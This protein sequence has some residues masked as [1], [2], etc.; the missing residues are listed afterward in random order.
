MLKICITGGSGFIGSHLLQVLEKKGVV[1]TILGRNVSTK[2][3]E[4]LSKDKVR[5]LKYDLASSANPS[6]DSLDTFDIL[7][8]LGGF[9]PRSIDR[10]DLEIGLRT[11]I[12]GTCNLLT[13]RRFRKVIYASTLEVY[14]TPKT[15][16]ITEDQTTDPT[17]YYGTSK[18]AGEK[19]VS[20][21][22]KQLGFDATILRFSSVY[23]SGEMYQRA[24]PNFI[25]RALQNQP[26]IIR[27]DGSDMRDYVHVAD[28]VDSIMLAMEGRSGVY[29]IASGVGYSIREIAEKILA[30]TGN[31]VNIS[32]ESSSKPPTKLVFDIS[33]AKEQLNYKPKVS[34]LEGLKEEIDWFRK[35]LQGEFKDEHLS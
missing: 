22:S 12:L 18:L 24:I 1:P 10:D 21:I 7:I 30:L 17:S 15:L 28:A 16:P 33:K 3:E 19:Y 29:N 8:H 34:I 5:F 20:A 14:G 11:N 6:L 26:L 23:G 4:L 25:R 32:F 35:M 2:I 27:G 13:H 9:V 31:V